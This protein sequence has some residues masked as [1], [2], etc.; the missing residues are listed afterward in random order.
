M[1]KSHKQQFSTSSHSHDFSKSKERKGVQ[2]ALCL[3]QTCRWFGPSLTS[4][5]IMLHH[6]VD[7]LHCIK[8]N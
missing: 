4:T 8:Q 7:E 1:A 6:L 3:L 2:E 5:P